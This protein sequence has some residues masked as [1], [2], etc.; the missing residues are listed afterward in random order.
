MSEAPRIRPC[1]P[2]DA[3]AA[4]DVWSRASRIAHP[5][6]PNEG[7]GERER[8]MRE[9]Y[10]VHADNWVAE[11]DGRVVGLLGLILGEIDGVVCGEIGG[12]FVAP[13][14]QGTGVGRLLVEHAATL[15][16]ALTLDVYEK[17]S[18]ARR[19]YAHVGFTEH[20]R[21]A[22]AAHDEILLKLVRPTPPG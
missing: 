6:I 20:S 22:D 5:F 3:D 1:L 16:S 12:L 9:T 4:V 7:A 14:A 19:F 11:A 8:E 18:R 15:H 17:N 10:L 2:V 21:R 13:E